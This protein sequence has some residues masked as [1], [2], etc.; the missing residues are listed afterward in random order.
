MRRA[1]VAYFVGLAVGFAGLLIFFWDLRIAMLGIDDFATIWV[2]PRAYLL[3]H[4]PYDPVTWRDT[5]VT[6]GS[7]RNL[8]Y[9]AVYLY[10]PWVVLALVPFA[11]LPVRVS[12]VVWTALGMFAAILAMRALL[13]EY[14]PD[15]DWAHGLV[16]LM[17]TFSSP[18]AVTY[19]TGQWTFF[20]V[21]MLAAIVLLLRARR[22]VASGLIAAG[23]LVKP[24]LFVFSAL[25]LGV[26]A[27]WPRAADPLGSRRFVFAAVG[28]GA[29]AIA[30]PWLVFPTWWPAWV[31][32]VAS[33][34]VGIVDPVTVQRLFIQL[35]GVGAAWLAAPAILA[36]V[37]VA[38]R[39]DPRSDAWIPIFFA[40]SSAAVV[41][42]NIYD[43]LLLV[44]PSVMAA[45]VTRS[46][47]R[48]AL[49]VLACTILLVPTMWSLHTGSDSPR[50]YAAAIS[51]LM[52]GIIAWTL[53][54]QRHEVTA[55]AS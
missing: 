21:A 30:I 37:A 53:W 18:A 43:L 1:D 9:T 46:P 13:R 52:F 41:Y 34:Q 11:L 19:L 39:S 16:G 8:S 48:R 6:V 31:N 49:V 15:L 17:L 47:Q 5:S 40:L 14:L 25:G 42:S 20:F 45:G 51:L 32:D 50:L 33:V 44:V 23:M 26:R 2:G 29:V 28:A 7:E 24:P 55:A 38:L 27:L 4:D 22:F 35:F 36:M 10:P 12:V 54:P 3:G